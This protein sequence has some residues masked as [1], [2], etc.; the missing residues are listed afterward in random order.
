MIHVPSRNMQKTGRKLLRSA[1]PASKRWPRD[2]FTDR[3][4]YQHISHLCLLSFR[5]DLVDL[6]N[7]DCSNAAFCVVRSIAP[8]TADNVLQDLFKPPHRV[9]FNPGHRTPLPPHMRT[10][11]NVSFAGLQMLRTRGRRACRRTEDAVPTHRGQRHRGPQ[12]DVQIC[13]GHAPSG[14]ARAAGYQVPV[15]TVTSSRVGDHFPPRHRGWVRV[16]GDRVR[17][18]GAVACTLPPRSRGWGG[19]RRD[20]GCDPK[21]ST[22]L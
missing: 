8:T 11:L 22:S 2:F 4:D 14:P 12:V 3:W 15:D 13:T 16:S 5:N 1:H 10:L 17:P 21:P 20:G 18:R 9:R 19:A 7:W 6:R